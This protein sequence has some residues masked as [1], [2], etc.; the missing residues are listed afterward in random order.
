MLCYCRPQLQL[1]PFLKFLMATS[2]FF[3]CMCIQDRFATSRNSPAIDDQQD[4]ELEDG[5][6]EDGFTVLKFTRK[7][8]TCDDKDLPITVSNQI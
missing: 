8:I 2:I 6:E 3:M 4:W 7:Y 5:Y 1:G